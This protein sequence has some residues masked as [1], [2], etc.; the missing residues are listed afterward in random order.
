MT[1]TE[2]T[3][4]PGLSRRGVLAGAVLVGASAAVAAPTAALAS[5]SRARG[6]EVIDVVLEPDAL[7]V[8]EEVPCGVVTF[9]VT[10]PAPAGRSLLLVR[11]AE[12]VTVDHYLQLL[13]GT[14]TQDPR[15]RAEAARAVSA[16][17]HNLGGA[18]VAANAPAGFSQVLSSGA[19]LLVNYGYAGGGPPTVR[20]I[21]AGGRRWARYPHAPG[22]IAHRSTSS[23][24]EFSAW[25]RLSARGRITVVN[26]T[27][28]PQE[29]MICRVQDGT[30]SEDV[31]AYFDA[32]RQGQQ[33]P[34]QP[35]LGRPVGMAPLGADQWGLLHTEFTPGPHV[36]FSFTVNHETGLNHA[37]EGMFR[38][39]DL[40]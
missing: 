35:I 7:D 22:V 3:T 13:R 5:E 19:Y 10:T 23:G 38:L 20:E 16:A 36:V 31:H 27:G 11:L 9:R 15:E 30:T 39:I 8:P 1:P 26:T 21:R 17:A 37:L 6:G 40:V 33:P 25:G 12:G 34:V 29:A 2:T 18:V 32:L 28:T 24:A 4:A 14:G